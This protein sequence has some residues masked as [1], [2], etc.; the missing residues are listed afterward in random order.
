V[1]Q[2]TGKPPASC[3]TQR[4]GLLAVCERVAAGE[5]P[6]SQR[7]QALLAL[8]EGATQV[9]AGGRAGLTQGQVRYWLGRF[10][11]DGL[12]IFP[13]SEEAE[14]TEMKAAGAAE[15][16]K[17]KKKKK[18]KKKQKKTGKAK[19][20]KKI[21]AKKKPKKKAKKAGQ[22]KKTKKKGKS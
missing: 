6:W 4:N 17:K 10:R 20:G 13:E 1:N 11:Q 2:K 19:K 22:S 21:K 14:A 5:A 16:P 12:S 18:K 7:A 15:E 9:G 8:D 3:S